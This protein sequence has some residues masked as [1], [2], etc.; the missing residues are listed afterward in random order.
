MNK[1]VLYTA[2]ACLIAAPLALGTNS[3]SSQDSQSMRITRGPWVESVQRNSAVIAWTTNRGGRGTVYYGTDSDNLSQTAQSN[4]S[5]SDHRV[6]LRNLRSNTQYFFTVDSG[7]GDNDRNGDNYSRSPIDSFVTSGDSYP[8]DGGG[9]GGQGTGRVPFYRFSSRDGGHF[10]T[11]SQP[12]ANNLSGYRSEGNIGYL[13]PPVPEGVVPLYRLVQTN[14]SAHYYTTDRNERERV[15]SQGYRYEGL[16][17]YVAS[18]QQPGT[19]PLY[20]LFNPR[21][22]DH[23]YT[24]DNNERQRALRQLGYVEDGIIGYIWTTPQ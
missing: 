16:A 7:R 17:G 6:T 18:S 21:T 24:I 19:T 23:L 20:R 10:Y 22:Q 8:G 2:I 9:G 1:V 11:A 12:E 5:N 13:Y 4:Y 3:Q 14:G 15:E